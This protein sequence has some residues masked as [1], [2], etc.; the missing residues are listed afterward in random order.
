MPS[1]MP[2]SDYP[3]EL[4]SSSYSYVI[5]KAKTTCFFT[6]L[7]MDPGVALVTPGTAPTVADKNILSSA[8]KAPYPMAA[9]HDS[10]NFVVS[11]NNMGRSRN[12]IELVI[13]G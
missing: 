4:L 11:S 6:K 13:R 8:P 7:K 3:Q 5:I 12:P 10:L 9:P 2:R 1:S